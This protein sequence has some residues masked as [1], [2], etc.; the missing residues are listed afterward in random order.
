MALALLAAP[1]AAEIELY[2]HADYRGA[3]RSFDRAVPDLQEL[4]WN[5]KASSIRIR[6]GS[7]E[8]CRDKEFRDCQTFNADHK[9][10]SNLRGWNDSIS[11]LR[12]LRDAEPEIEAF[13]DRAYG[14]PSRAFFGAMD[15]LA[16]YGWN[17][18]ISSFRVVSGRWLICRHAGY[19][20]CREI[21]GDEA[22]LRGEWN[23]SISSLRPLRP[24]RDN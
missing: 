1:V 9:D 21:G 8:V 5:D 6:R 15:S 4:G 10:L 23:D 20:D 12:R 7:W 22:E 2:E 11:S 3:S 17:D 13:A 18:R 24:F 14:G 16:R 19:R